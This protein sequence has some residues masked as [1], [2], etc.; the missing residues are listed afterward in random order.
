MNNIYT[1]MEWIII[2]HVFPAYMA[3]EARIIQLAY[4]IY[5]TV[6]R[7]YK[8]KFLTFLTGNNNS[9]WKQPCTIKI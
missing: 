1:E 7:L 8:N 9:D 2:L 3:I 6:I 5:S 4:I